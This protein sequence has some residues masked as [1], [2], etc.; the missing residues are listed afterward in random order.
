MPNVLWTIDHSTRPLDEFLSLLKAHGI[1]QLVDIRTV[2]RSRYNPQFNTEALAQSVA[3]EAIHYRHSGSLGG[4]RKPHKDSI[5][6][7][8][9][10]ASFRGHADDVQTEKLS[11]AVED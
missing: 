8:W 9:R 10:N 1:E 5:N 11:E 2:P 6:I 3:Q 4:L 7:G